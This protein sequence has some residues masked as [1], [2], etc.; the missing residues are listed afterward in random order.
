MVRKLRSPETTMGQVP[1]EIAVF[2]ARKHP[3][4]DVEE[5]KYA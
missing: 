4:R 2:F 1:G 3:V 5:E